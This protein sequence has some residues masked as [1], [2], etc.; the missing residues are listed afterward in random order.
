MSNIYRGHHIEQ[1]PRV[2]D[3][4]FGAPHWTDSYSA[5]R[6]I[7][8]AWQHFDHGDHCRWPSHA[9]LRNFQR[10]CGR[11]YG[12]RPQHLV[13]CVLPVF[14]TLIGWL[15][16]ANGLALLLV[17]SETWTAWLVL[18]QRLHYGY[19]FYFC[20]RRSPSAAIWPLPVSL[21]ADDIRPARRMADA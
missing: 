1:L 16:F 20:F 13:R 3:C 12:Q 8:G 15:I 2:L 11:G 4:L 9:C 6:W 7:F 10:C 5:R 19:P 18:L 17:P 21:R 14:V